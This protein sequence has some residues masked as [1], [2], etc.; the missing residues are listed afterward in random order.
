M[1]VYCSPIL[2]DHITVWRQKCRCLIHL[3]FKQRA[4]HMNV[5]LFF[6]DDAPLRVSNVALCQR[7]SSFIKHTVKSITGVH[8]A[9]FCSHCYFPIFLSPSAP[10]AKDSIHKTED[11]FFMFRMFLFK[12]CVM[13]TMSMCLM[14]CMNCLDLHKVF[15]DTWLCSSCIH[16]YIQCQYWC[17]LLYL[18]VCLM[19]E[20]KCYTV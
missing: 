6:W 13:I 4:Y 10:K 8:F 11:S 7:F 17:L 16:H 2:F 15:L 19:E 9:W 12:M 18:F 20:N 14:I 1:S 5:H 3:F